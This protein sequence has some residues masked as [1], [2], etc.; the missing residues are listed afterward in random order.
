MEPHLKLVFRESPGFVPKGAQPYQEGAMPERE[1]HFLGHSAFEITTA[2]GTRLLIDPY[3]T[4]NAAC[5]Y[6][7]EQIRDPDIILVSHGAADHYGDTLEL[8]QRSQCV[9]LC[10][11][12]VRRHLSMKGIPQ[13]RLRLGVWG[14]SIGFRDVNIRVVESRHLSI[15]ATETEMLS[16][17]GLGFIINT[18]AEGAIYHPGDTSIFSDARLIGQLHRPKVG[19]LTAATEMTPYEAALMANWLGLEYAIPMHYRDPGVA[20]EFVQHLKREAPNAKPL[21][22]SPGQRVKV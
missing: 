6:T 7:L 5:P 21:V 15:V 8:A 13:E 22:M 17:M 16:G 3:I 9:I 14:F 10:D 2:Q 1:I 11:P 20:E 12:A 19:M 18:G 4:Q